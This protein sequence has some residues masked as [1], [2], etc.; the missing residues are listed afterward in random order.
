MAFRFL[1]LDTETGGLDPSYSLL[2][3]YFLATDDKFNIKSELDLKIKPDKGNFVTSEGA[4]KKNKI[5][6]EKH[7]VEAIN[8]SSATQKLLVFL[9][10][11]SDGGR[12]KLIPVGHNIGFDLDFIHAKLLDKKAWHDYCSKIVQD[13]CQTG[14]NLKILGI[15][16]SNLFNSLEA[17]GEYYGLP[18]KGLHDARNDVILN[19]AV[20]R[21]MLSGRLL[22]DQQRR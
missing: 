8:E 3:A 20:Y 18:R 1:V 12:E 5:N 17:Y 14:L 9:D 10:A 22:L 15:L 19:L 21:K 6:L 4:L 16:P 2:T 11:A 7:A 13:T